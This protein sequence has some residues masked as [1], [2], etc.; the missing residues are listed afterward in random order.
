MNWL[1]SLFNLASSD[2]RQLVVVIPPFRSDYKNLLPPENFLFEKLNK[3]EVDGLKILNYYNSDK[4]DDTDF[5]DA[6]HLNENGAI[7]LTKEIH[8]IFKERMWL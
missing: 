6:D 4:F 3:L 8:S 5:G 2:G 1:K 7:K